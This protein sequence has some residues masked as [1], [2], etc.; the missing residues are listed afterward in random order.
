MKT[1]EDW[2]CRR[3]QILSLLEG[4][5]SGALPG[6][7][8]S[9]TAKFTQSGTKGTLAITAS[10]GGSSITFSPTITFPS[11]NP[12]A[13]G[14]PLVIAYDGLSIPVP[15]NVSRS[16]VACTSEGGKS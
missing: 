9:V 4:Y 5:E 16:R 14:W 15:S 10:H 3:A 11:G 13:G 1:K 8:E 2:E 12:P 6:K 7:P